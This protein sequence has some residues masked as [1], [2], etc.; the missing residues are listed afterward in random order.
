MLA[1]LSELQMSGFVSNRFRQVFASSLINT[2]KLDW[3]EGAYLFE[4]YL[5]DY[6]VYSNYGN[7]QYLAGV[8]L[9]PRGK[10]VFDTLKQISTY[11]LNY[12][13]IKLWTQHQ[14]TQEIK[15]LLERIYL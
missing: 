4:R 11:D 10:R 14:S 12:D 9:D 15:N 6:D 7:W 8:G 13:Y 2:Y 3:R 1:V 5:I